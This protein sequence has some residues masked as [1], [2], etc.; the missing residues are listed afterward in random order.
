MA[1]DIE[2]ARYAS[3][4]L[5]SNMNV[6]RDAGHVLLVDPFPREGVLDGCELDAILL[7][8]EHYDHISGI[9]YW[10]NLT[11][12]QI[13]C[14]NACAAGCCDSRRNLSRYSGTIADMAIWAPAGCGSVDAFEC[15]VEGRFADEMRFEWQGHDVWL[16]A[17]PGHS[18]GSAGI[19]LD[20]SFLFSGDSLLFGMKTELRFPGG[21]VA[22]WESVGKPRLQSLD[23]GIRVY[24]G[25]F[26]SFVLADYDCW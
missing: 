2:I 4:F 16:F 3:K 10:R 23:P 8:H 7:T 12:A 17:C 15:D 6:V 13:V 26:D 1:G 19:V 25:H 9:D 20:K 22:E 18:P 14:S 24:P 21:S 11:D 5:A